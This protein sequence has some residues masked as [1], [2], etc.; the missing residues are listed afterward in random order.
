[1][2]DH[3]C[4]AFGSG[5]MSKQNVYRVFKEFKEEDKTDYRG[6]RG[7]HESPRGTAKQRTEGNI[8]KIHELIKEDAR[9]TFEALSYESG[10]GIGTVKR[11]VK[12]DLKVSPR[13]QFQ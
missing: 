11:I 4:K 5:A 1:M 9:M 12:E 6:Q 13:C 10:I 8:N 2:Y 3:L 7:Q